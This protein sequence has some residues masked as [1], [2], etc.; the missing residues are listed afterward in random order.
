MMD[1]WDICVVSDRSDEEIAN[2]LADSIRKYRLPSGTASSQNDIDYRKILLDTQET[3][4][5]DKVQEQLDMA[6]LRWLELSEFAE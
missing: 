3:P 4:C 2:S 5:D 6:E 1:K